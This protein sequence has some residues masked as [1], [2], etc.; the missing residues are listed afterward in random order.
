MGC[1]R[2]IFCASMKTIEG[3]FSEEEAV[4]LAGAAVHALREL[5]DAGAVVEV[6]SYCG[7]ATVIVA[8]A[9]CA[10][11]TTATSVRRRSTRRRRRRPRH[12]SPPRPADLRAVLP[13][14]Q[15]GGNG[16]GGRADPHRLLRRFWQRS[17]GLLFIDGLHDY[18]SVAADFYH[19]EPHVLPG[20]YVAFHDYADYFPGVQAF[21]NELLAGGAYCLAGRAG[22]LVVAQ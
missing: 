5:P 13:Q 8:E 17:I 19:F 4:L 7:R 14:Y 2:P 6:G 15:G 3:W 12:G 18:P 9:V 1:R 21:A 11:K 10:A 22:S 16:R 20:G